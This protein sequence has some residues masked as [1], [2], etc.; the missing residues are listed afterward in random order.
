M[1]TGFGY[2]RVSTQKQ[3]LGVSLEVQR[4]VIAEFA[5]TNGIE[6]TQWFEE[7]E[8]AAKGGRPIFN[9]MMRQLGRRKASALII[10]KIDRSARNMRDWSRVLDLPNR[11]VELHFAAEG[12]D[13]SSRGGRLAANLQA[14][15]AEDYIFNLREETIKGMLGRLKQGLYPFRAP[16]GYLDNGRGQPKTPCLS[17]APLIRHAFD[18]YCTGGFSINSLH[19]EM[20]RLGLRNH[21]GK[22]VSKHG[23]ETIL[24]NPFYCG[25][26]EIRRTGE[27]YQGIHEPI[28][29]TQVF[30]YVQDLKAG[31]AGKK[32]TRHNHL[33]RGMFRC[34][35]CNT[36]MIPERQKGHVYYRCHRS[37]CPKNTI[38]E[39]RLDT[40]IKGAYRT[41]QLTRKDAIKLKQDWLAWLRTA[42]R[43]GGLK[44]IELRISNA[45]DRLTRLT[46]LLLDGS[47]DKTDHTQRKRKMTFELA[48][49]REER[50]QLRKSD[51]S[52]DQIARFLELATN[53][54]ELHNSL[55]HDEKRYLIENCFSNRTVSE[56]QPEMKPYSWIESRDFSELTPLVTQLGPL[57]ELLS[58][59]SMRRVVEPVKPKE[60][61]WKHN[62]R[63]Q[64]RL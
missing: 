26:I 10:H 19:R 11:G 8:T 43:A 37:E 58:S 38:R 7:K 14:V 56:N 25:I 54:T 35:R 59:D 21:S 4:D 55:N 63:N 39:D 50:D 6:I 61:Q 24:R 1:K 42:E 36:S 44:S 28:I 32:V 51:L 17:K 41:V 34:A 9:D 62:L 27:T 33:Y 48:A 13:F 46:D 30:Q 29:T 45:E 23:I 52:E 57:L 40:F 15:I 47:I 60:P 18:L 12:L 49:L 53:L 2:I 16:I 3:G 20:D 64:G 31:K 5:A 22:A